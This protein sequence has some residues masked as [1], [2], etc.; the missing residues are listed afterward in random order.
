MLLSFYVPRWELLFENYK[1]NRDDFDYVAAQD[2]LIK[3]EATWAD[4]PGIPQSPQV[5]PRL[6]T[7]ALIQGIIAKY[8]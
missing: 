4:A 6:E 2:A 1:K 8:K 5:L 3:W 7:L